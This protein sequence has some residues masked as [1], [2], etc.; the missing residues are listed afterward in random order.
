VFYTLKQEPTGRPRFLRQTDACLLC[1]GSSQ[2]QGVPG[3]LVRS[4][5]CDADGLPV[6]S[7]GSHRVDQTSPLA[8]RWGGWFVTGTHGTQKH[9]GNLIV[10]GQ[11]SPEE[12]DNSAGMNLTDL[13]QRI[14]LS[15]YLTGHSDIVA[16]LVLE[17]QTQGHNL[18]A[19]ANFLT[20]AALYH[21]TMLNKEL[22]KPVDER[23]ESTTSRIKDA[24]EPL[25]RY[26]LFSEETRLTA[27][28]KGTSGFAEEFSARGPR[29]SRGRSLRDFDLESRLFKYPCSYLIYSP[30]FDALPQAVKDYVWNRL[31]EVLSGRDASPQF[32]HLSA[33]DRQSIREIV[34]ATKSAVPRAWPDAASPP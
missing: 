2:T 20:R 10:R 23:W 13:S 32:A 17:H 22:G 34:A 18:I 24:G 4:V 7:F 1:H 21:E 25:V 12:V 11:R 3:H 9:L 6:L 19:R 8:E 14:D 28:I 29:D 31:G 30:S 15:D 5:Y 33:S 16:L 26:L 27:R